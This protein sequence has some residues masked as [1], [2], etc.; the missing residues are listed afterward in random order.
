M[1]K[2]KEIKLQFLITGGILTLLDIAST[3]ETQHDREHIAW[4]AAEEII[5]HVKESK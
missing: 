2:A 1:A 4:H 5:K 3:A